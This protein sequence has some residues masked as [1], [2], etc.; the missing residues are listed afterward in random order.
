MSQLA[1]TSLAPVLV[2]A[3]TLLAQAPAAR[4]ELVSCAHDAD[5][6]QGESCVE[7]R[8]WELSGGVPD[9]CIGYIDGGPATSCRTPGN[10][11]AAAEYVCGAAGGRLEDQLHGDG[12]GD[13]RYRSALNVCCAPDDGEGQ[14]VSGVNVRLLRERVREQVMSDLGC[15]GG[16]APG[17]TPLA[18]AWLAALLVAM[19][20][21][22]RS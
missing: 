14:V 16:R 7:E 18:V 8:C 2:A 17:G 11:L 20:R 12:C 10:L 5:C 3:S 15:A 22:W 4:A 9:R 13:G 19:R 1:V 6:A 21:R